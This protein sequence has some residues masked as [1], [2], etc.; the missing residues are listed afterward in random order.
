MA[1]PACAPTATISRP[2]SPA[3]I[4]PSASAPELHHGYAPAV[5]GL[6]IKEFAADTTVSPGAQDWALQL[7]R[8]HGLL[9]EPS[10][11][12]TNVNLFAGKHTIVAGG[13]YSYT[14]LNIANN[15][16]GIAQI[17]TKTTSKA[18]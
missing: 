5:P 11:P 18:S 2:Y 3:A 17:D 1:S 6:T 16:N 15:R 13:G 4:E 10:E 12:S 8:E 9:S 7:L 14:Q